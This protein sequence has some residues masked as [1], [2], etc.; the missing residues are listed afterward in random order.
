MGYG[1]GAVY[2]AWYGGMVWVLCMGVWYG[3]CVWGGMI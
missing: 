2:R 1:M 3:C